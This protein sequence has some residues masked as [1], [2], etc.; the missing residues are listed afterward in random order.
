MPNIT[1]YVYAWFYMA[2]YGSLWLCIHLCY[3]LYAI[4]AVGCHCVAR[5]GALMRVASLRCTCIAFA[6]YATVS[7][8]VPFNAIV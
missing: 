7:I 2:L 1:L 4:D 5:Y 6:C 3:L 8:C